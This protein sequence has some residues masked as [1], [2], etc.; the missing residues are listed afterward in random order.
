VV[1]AQTLQPLSQG[2]SEIRFPPGYGIPI[3]SAEEFSLATQALNLNIG[4]RT[5]DVRVKVEVD[6]LR[7]SELTTAM[8]PLFMKAAN[9]LVLVE[10]EDRYGRKFS[11]HW[12][13]KPGR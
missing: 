6:Y 7:D 13:V 9:G 5:F 3:S 4:D 2:Q 11:G 8:K 12:V 1:D 10:G